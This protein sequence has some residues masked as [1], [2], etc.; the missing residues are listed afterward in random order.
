MQLEHLSSYEPSLAFAPIK[1]HSW[2]ELSAHA[3][4]HNATTFKQLIG[5]HR[6]LAFVV[7]ANAYGHGIR[8][9]SSIA[10]TIAEIDFLC[11]FSL[12]EALTIRAAGVAKPIIVLSFIDE[13]PA[14]AIGNAIAFMVDN[15]EQ[16]DLLATTARTH[17]ARIPV[18]I[19]VYTGLSRFGINSKTVVDFAQKI[20]A[21]KSLILQGLA[22]HLSESQEKESAVTIHQLNLFT[23]TLKDLHHQHIA[24]PLIHAANSAACLQNMLDNSTLV[25][26]GLGLY[27]FMP[28]THIQD[29]I[30]S[31]NQNFEL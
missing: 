21:T 16:I 8:E 24:P 19:K 7:K 11:T 18:Q 30:M 10:D 13:D 15:Q 27:G 5:T 26:V 25:R 1:N 29:Q 22:T 2:I 9:I 14:Y 20:I 6:A 28:A 23:T 3:L 4:H 31:K 17:A 12:S